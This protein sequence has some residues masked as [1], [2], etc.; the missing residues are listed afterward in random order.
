M[1]ARTSFIV[2]LTLIPAPSSLGQDRTSPEAQKPKTQLLK[3]LVNDFQ[4]ELPVDQATVTIKQWPAG[5]GYQSTTSESGLCGFPGLLVGHTYR[6]TVKQ[7]AYATRRASLTV[8]EKMPAMRVYLLPGFPLQGTLSPAP[9]GRAQI[10]LRAQPGSET[11][12]AT[13]NSK[14]AVPVRPDGS[15]GPLKI[16]VGKYQ[17][18][19]RDARTGDSWEW[20]LDTDSL[21]GPLNLERK[22]GR[23]EVSGLMLDESGAARSSI[24]VRMRELSPDS[25]T[26]WRSTQTTQDGSF[27]FHDVPDGSYIVQPLRSMDRNFFA[28][29]SLVLHTQTQN[30]SWGL[31]QVTVNEEARRATVHFGYDSNGANITGILR[32]N[33]TP[34]SGWRV[35][36]EDE[37]GENIWISDFSRPDGMF[38]LPGLE[39]DH[40]YQVTYVSPHASI[41]GTSIRV[42]ATEREVI[43]LDIPQ[44]E[45]TGQVFVEGTRFSPD[46]GE[47]QIESQDAEEDAPPRTW[48]GRLAADGTFEV[49]GLPRGKYYVTFHAPGFRSARDELVIERE[50]AAHVDLVLWTTVAKNR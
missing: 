8:T 49:P 6:V 21:R 42:G 25:A 3:V 30:A 48:W 28:S 37:K 27:V 13:E 24:Q 35:R 36:F 33:E 12:Y 32:R 11:A 45:V 40:E 10:T 26:P 19:H 2:L 14:F 20:A 34:L 31:K 7:G 41:P 38:E 18:L 16:G 44:G 39:R 15:F 5:K 17:V 1:A 29:E 9:Q 50:E 47:V 43:W 23:G 22:Q 46:E 4:T